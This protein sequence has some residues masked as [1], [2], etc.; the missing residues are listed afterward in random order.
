MLLVKTHRVVTAAWLPLALNVLAAAQS[1]T[2]RARR[3]EINSISVA[4]DRR[5]PFASAC[6]SGQSGRVPPAR[7]GGSRA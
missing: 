5:A 1:T 2:S 6:R 4:F 7:K 3:F